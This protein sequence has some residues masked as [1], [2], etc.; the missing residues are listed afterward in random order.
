MRQDHSPALQSATLQ[1]Q[2]SAM[3]MLHLGT[4]LTPQQSVA[5]VYPVEKGQQVLKL[6]SRTLI[7]VKIT[8]ADAIGI[9][10]QPSSS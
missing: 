7:L 10:G 6:R 2:R 1:G 9:R 4:H 5:P 8:F 3:G